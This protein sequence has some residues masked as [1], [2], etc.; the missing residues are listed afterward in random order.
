MEG[1]QQEKPCFWGSASSF[2][3]EHQTCLSVV[4][5][6]WL[7]ERWSRAACLTGKGI[8]LHRCMWFCFR[9]HV[10]WLYLLSLLTSGCITLPLRPFW[11]RTKSLDKC[12]PSLSLHVC[13]HGQGKLVSWVYFESKSAELFVSWAIHWCILNYLCVWGLFFMASAHHFLPVR[14]PQLLCRG[15]FACQPDKAMIEGRQHNCT[16]RVMFGAEL[17]RWFLIHFFLQI[18]FPAFLELTSRRLLL[19]ISSPVW[20]S[21]IRLKWYPWLIFSVSENSMEF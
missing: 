9:N 20:H 11:H 21:K 17:M 10:G 2:R 5:R 12:W 13:S 19:L 3:M 1:S 15:P 14:T 16:V 4:E 7:R 18:K 6:R 8:N